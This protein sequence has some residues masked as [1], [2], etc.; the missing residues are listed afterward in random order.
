MKAVTKIIL[1]LFLSLVGVV[2]AAPHQSVTKILT[3]TRCCPSVCPDRQLS[4]QEMR[5]CIA[6][7]EATVPP[8]HESSSFLYW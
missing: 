2:L 4:C 6:R 7:V 1:P 3:K 5:N 8:V